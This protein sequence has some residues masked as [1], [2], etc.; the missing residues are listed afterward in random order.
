MAANCLEKLDFLL[1]RRNQI[2][3][4][5]HRMP[6]PDIQIHFKLVTLLGFESV[7]KKNASKEIH[8]IKK[9]LRIF[10]AHTTVSYPT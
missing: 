1:E 2:G 5:A 7:S 9:I 8:Y 10:Q 3:R 4:L 6:P